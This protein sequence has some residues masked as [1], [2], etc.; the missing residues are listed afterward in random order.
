MEEYNLDSKAI[1]S[2]EE[3]DN[4]YIRLWI[5]LGI[6]DHD[7]VYTDIDVGGE[8]TE[9]ITAIDLMNPESLKT[10]VGLPI[11]VDHPPEPITANNWKK[12]SVG[13]I[14]QEFSQ[15]DSVPVVAS[16]INDADT[17][18][19]IKNG[20]IK[21][22]SSAYSAV[23]QLQS[24]GKLQQKRRTYNHI[25]LLTENHAPRAGSKSQLVLDS[26][27]KQG[28]SDMTTLQELSSKVD[29]LANLVGQLLNKDSLETTEESAETT[30]ESVDATTTEAT[31]EATA[32]A[33]TEAT[34]E[35][36]AEATNEA[37][38]ETA[39][40]DD[41]LDDSSMD[42]TEAP[43]TISADS[44]KLEVAERAAIMAKYPNYNLDASTPSS[45]MKRQIIAKVRGKAVADKLTDD[46]TLKGFWL[47]FDSVKKRQ[48]VATTTANTDS[49]DPALD[50][51]KRME[52]KAS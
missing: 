46:A 3:T 5:P 43:E 42:T 45:D 6:P 20:E 18:K 26:V 32:E 15:R 36:V 1:L 19:R 23:K 38:T 50:F 33:T 48:T 41:E 31:A 12:Y 16:I 2:W 44:I 14:L 10:L 25:S 9:F 11:S 28:K 21:F 40:E 13:S 30:A 49:S 22:T 34:T 29:K 27:R 17:C 7:L 37:T 51:I 4:G 35:V 39:T 8:R 24:D 47:S 52:G